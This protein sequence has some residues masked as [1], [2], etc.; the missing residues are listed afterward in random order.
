VWFYLLEQTAVELDGKVFMIS[1]DS[2]LEFTLPW[3]KPD[4]SIYIICQSMFHQF[5]GD[6]SLSGSLFLPD[7]DDSDIIPIFKSGLS[8]KPI[9]QSKSEAVVGISNTPAVTA[10]VVDGKDPNCGFSSSPPYPDSKTPWKK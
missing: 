6:S 5:S 2:D 9:T 10:K 4:M 8:T 7:L 1:S 3:K